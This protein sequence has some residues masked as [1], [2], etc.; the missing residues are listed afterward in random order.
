MNKN[1]C[2]ITNGCIDCR[3]QAAELQQV[4]GG[5]ATYSPCSDYTQADLVVFLGCSITQ[6][7]ENLSCRIIEEIDARKRPGAQLLPVGCIVKTRPDLCRNGAASEE[8]K[9]TVDRIVHFA[10]PAPTVAHTPQPEFWKIAGRLFPRSTA[11]KLVTSYCRVSRPGILGRVSSA[12]GF[13]LINLLVRYRR[14]IDREL[15][16]GRTLCIRTCTGCMGQCTYCSIRKSRGWIRSKPLDQILKEF[17][18]GREGGY[19]DFAL[20]GTD[21]GDYGKDSGIDLINLLELLV[22]Q[23]GDFKLRLRNV[24]PRWLIPS[25]DRFCDVVR[26]GKVAYVLSPLESASDRVLQSMGRG[27]CA[28]DFIAAIRKVRAANPRIFLKTQI[29]VGFPGERAEDFMESEELVAQRLFDYIE[30]YPYSARPGTQAAAY[31]DQIAAPTIAER[32][33]RLLFKSFFLNPMRDVPLRFL[34]EKVRI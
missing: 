10:E 32:Y 30:L 24:N 7:K 8:L 14:Y 6:D 22:G 12:I 33:R 29:M 25:V 28:Q 27:Y 1:V 9:G 31:P 16:P 21:L 13:G 15:N 11:A 2:V 4:L 17:R 18:T 34:K 5:A 23:P 3:M 20:V 26:T 19:K